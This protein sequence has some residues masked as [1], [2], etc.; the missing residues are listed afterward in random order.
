MEEYCYKYPRPAVT[1]DCVVFGFD[2]ERLQVLL[3]QRG[4]EPYKGDWAFP[5]GFLN[6][7][8]TA[9]EGAVRELEEE[10][11]IRNVFV[12]QLQ[13]FS[14]VDRDPRGRTITIAYYALVNPEKMQVEGRDDA[15]DARWFETGNLPTLVFDHAEMYETACRQLALKIY[16]QVKGLER[17]EEYFRQFDLKQLFDII[18]GK[19]REYLNLE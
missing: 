6:M 18:P 5:G 2:G 9:E 10:T 16:M 14:A 3:I 13:V 12:E 11:G 4:M 17:P 7:D 8:E 15:A 1:T 19:Y